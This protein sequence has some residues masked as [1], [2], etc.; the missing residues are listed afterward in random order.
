MLY[1]YP[2]VISSCIAIVELYKQVLIITC[3]VGVLN[4]E[5]VE[6]NDQ[7]EVDLNQN[8]AILGKSSKSRRDQSELKERIFVGRGSVYRLDRIQGVDFLELSVS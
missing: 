8:I 7:S 5:D 3:T 2:C 6:D 4:V 1:A